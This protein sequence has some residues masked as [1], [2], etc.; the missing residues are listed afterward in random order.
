MHWKKVQQGEPNEENPSTVSSEGDFTHPSNQ[1][2][3]KDKMWACLSVIL[4]AILS[5]CLLSG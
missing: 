4:V 5:I 3:S 1:V 2:A